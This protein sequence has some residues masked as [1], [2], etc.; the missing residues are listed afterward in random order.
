MR[1][2]PKCPKCGEQLREIIYGMATEDMFNNPNYVLGG[3]IIEEDAADYH[4]LT[5]DKDF[6]E[7]ELTA[8]N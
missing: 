2:P 6:R 7:R 4:C 5:C 1:V 3:C 8:R